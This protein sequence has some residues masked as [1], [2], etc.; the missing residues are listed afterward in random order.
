MEKIAIKDFLYSPKRIK[1]I[2]IAK[3][4]GFI[5]MVI[6]HIIYNYSPVRGFIYSFHMPLFFILSFLTLSLSNDFYGYKKNLK[7]RFFRILLPYYFA[8]V[9]MIIIDIIIKPS[10]FINGT[11]WFNQLDRFFCNAGPNQKAAVGALWFI[12]ALFLVENLFDLLHLL[13]K[14]EGLFFIAC[15]LCTLIGVILGNKQIYLYLVFDL[16]LASMIFCY[17]GYYLRRVDL[18]KHPLVGLVISAG[19]WLAVL[20]LIT[21]KDFRWITYFEMWPRRYLVWMFDYIC[22]IAGS[23]A[24]IYLSVLVSKIKIF[25]TGLAYLGSHNMASLFSHVFSSMYLWSRLQIVD[26]SLV[27]LNKSLIEIMVFILTISIVTAIQIFKQ[28][29]KRSMN[30]PTC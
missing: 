6:G 10:R 1:W 16:V 26:K 29:Y 28:K 18:N 12:F 24:V 17:V 11:F 2:D 19:I 27:Y 3:I 4:F 15:F 30:T 25:S 23:L 20:L 7:K 13:I 21:Y 8:V 14:D 9:L 22:A 5:L